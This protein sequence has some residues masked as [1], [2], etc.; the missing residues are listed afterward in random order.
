[1]KDLGK[2]WRSALSRCEELEQLQGKIGVWHVL[3]T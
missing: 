3:D 1:M 2:R